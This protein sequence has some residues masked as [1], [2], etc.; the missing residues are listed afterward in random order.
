MKRYIKGELVSERHFNLN[1]K[2]FWNAFL[3]NPGG[4]DFYEGN[5]LGSWDFMAR[6]RFSSGETVRAYFE[7]PWEDGS[8][9]GRRNGWDG[10][11]GLEYIAA[12]RNGWLTGALVEYLDFT[13]QS[14]PSTLP[15][16]TA[17]AQPLPTNQQAA[18]TTITTKCIT[19][20]PTTECR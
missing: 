12:D 10:L 5:H 11:W 9:I 19:L 3:P 8:G 7:W 4:E 14:G 15:P 2:S 1:F 6:Y 20:M 17:P 13:N 18:T 16:V